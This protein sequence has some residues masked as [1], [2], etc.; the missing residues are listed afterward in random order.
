MSTPRAAE[1]CI[2]LNADVGEGYPDDQIV[3]LVTSANVA[4]GAHAGD[5]TTMRAT[6]RLARAHGVR[7]GAH[8]GFADRAGFGRHVTTR[9]PAAIAQLV[10]EQIA[11]LAR[12][13]ADE[14]IVLSHVKPH[15]ALYAL[16]ADDDAI[17]DAIAAT[18][19]QLVPAAQLIGRARSRGLA[20]ASAH[21]L[22][23]LAEG[24]ADRAYLRDG[25]LAPRDRAGAL[26]E[27]PREAARRAL[28][29]ASAGT[30]DTLDGTTLALHVDTICLHGDAP[31]AAGRARTV[32]AALRAAGVR[33]AAPGPTTTSRPPS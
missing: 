32:H 19:A 12:V 11:T 2:D 24:F 13:A 6:L 27:D 22:V 31:D 5:E 17:A 33:L 20:R 1:R 29:L 28:Q 10:G 18:V 15:G 9:D 3:P 26:I 23:V 25:T 8:P 16:A 21:G 4:C 14:G 7:V 30:V